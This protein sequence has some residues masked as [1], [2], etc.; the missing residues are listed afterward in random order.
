MTFRFP[1]HAAAAAAVLFLAARA[2][3]PADQVNLY[4]EEMQEL[5]NSYLAEKKAHDET[6]LQALRTILNEGKARYDAMF[7]EQK[8]SGNINGMAVARTGITSFEGFSDQLQKTGDFAFQP[9]VRREL[10]EHLSQVKTRKDELDAARKAAVDALEGK[11]LD[12]F[13]ERALK[14]G[15]AVAD[16]AALKQLFTDLLGTQSPAGTQPGAGAGTGPEGAVPIVQDSGAASNFVTFARWYAE[17]RSIEILKISVA[18]VEESASFSGTS[19]MGAGY[20]VRYEAIR[21]ISP[22][23]AAVF[24]AMPV[25]G[26]GS[27]DVLEWPSAKN[28]WTM[29]IRVRP[30]SA[31]P[32]EHALEL[33]VGYT[34]AETVPVIRGAGQADEPREDALAA[35]VKMVKVKVT[36][37]PAGA[38]VYVDGRREETNGAPV[39]TPCTVG[40]RE[41]RRQVKLSLVGFADVT[42]NGFMPQDGG[43]IT[44][45]FQR[46]PRFTERRLQVSSR[47]KWRNS[48][49]DVSPGEVV[50]IEVEGQWSCGSKGEMA[51]PDGYPNDQQFFHYYIRPDLAPRPY[52]KFNYGAL[53]VRVG[54]A[55]TVAAV[56]RDFKARIRSGGSLQFGIN[57]EESAHG[58][59]SG[60]LTV[61]IRKGP[62]GD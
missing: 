16:P 22:P 55:D 53:L 15:A 32:S 26:K 60:A 41:G 33:Q 24:R 61:T 10:E 3:L 27:A 31:I 47:G 9:K 25:R 23:D 37:Q 48:G 52:K 7:K 4:V 18:G 42:V 44:H 17:V 14:Q 8:I 51:G 28:R 49:I 59:N 45:L 46:D 62:A 35:V 6:R 19:V 12:A 40:I 54:S 30:G 1:V 36:T 50:M 29:T 2:A 39:V 5:K 56:T 13:R 43:E 11:F 21:S 38:F 57:E 20:S 58:D 34:G